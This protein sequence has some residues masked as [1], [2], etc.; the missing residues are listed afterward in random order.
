M[1][2][3]H[4]LNVD[5]ASWREWKDACSI[6]N[7]HSDTTVSQLVSFGRNR[8]GHALRRYSPE[9]ANLYCDPD[10]RNMRGA[11]LKVEQYL[12]AGTSGK[13]ERDG[14]AYKDRLVQG[15][16]DHAHFEAV[17][18]LKI[19]REI[20]RWIL[21]DEGFD[22]VQKTDAETGHKKYV[23]TRARNPTD[24]ELDD[25]QSQQDG[26]YAE[27]GTEEDDEAIE[28]A[29]AHQAREIW[30]TLDGKRSVQRLILVCLFYNVWDMK[31]LLA[32]GLTK[33]KQSQLY[34]ERKAVLNLFDALDW[35]PGCLGP[36]QRAYMTRRLLPHLKKICDE[37]LEAV[38]NQKVKLFIETAV[39]NDRQ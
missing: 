1:S 38:E 8:L 9:T 14:K 25:C 21:A 2:K 31:A 32:S 24:E 6:E 13:Q 33:C 35:G 22:I 19:Q 11:W 4:L 20:A 18:S 16:C 17:L 30:Q 10:G 39:L 37:W 34:N 29:A 7:C 27:P 15:C 12:Y 23:V 36:G 5:E 28:R 26:V 3:A